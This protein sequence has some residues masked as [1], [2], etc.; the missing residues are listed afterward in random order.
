[1]KTK[2]ERMSRLEKKDLYKKYKKD[3]KEF[4]IKMERMFL[5]CYVGIGYSLII[6]IYDFFFKKS[7]INYILDIIIFVFCLV[8]Y[9][10]IYNTKKELL[11]NYAIK[12]DKEYKRSIVKKYKK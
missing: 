10:K 7:K 4:V 11:N 8:A 6:F 3:K 12:N 1:M 5:L 9:L 2:Y